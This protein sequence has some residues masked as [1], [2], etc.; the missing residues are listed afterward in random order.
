MD[1]GRERR[2]E[3]RLQYKW[4]VL[5]SEDFTQRIDQG[6]MVDVSS[7]GIAFSC[8]VE[9]GYLKEDQHLTVQFSLPRSEET[10]SSAMVSITRTGRVCRID[11]ESETIFRIGIQFDKPLT[12][13]PYELAQI[14]LMRNANSGS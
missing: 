4:P 3:E 11:K 5:F 13:K 10:D 6:L 14:Q 12:L 2:T 8:T 7:G 9:T 1:E